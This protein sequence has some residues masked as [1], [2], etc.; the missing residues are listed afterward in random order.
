MVGP[1]RAPSLARPL[2]LAHQSLLQSSRPVRAVTTCS[3]GEEALRL[4]RETQP[5]F[6]LVISDVMMPGEINGFQLL[7][8][9]ARE[10]NVP[11]VSARLLPGAVQRS[12][13]AAR[14]Q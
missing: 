3:S 11:V 13:D 1:F 6:N 12:A 2:S 7:D 5:R 8:C 14:S 4:L 9:I 10:L